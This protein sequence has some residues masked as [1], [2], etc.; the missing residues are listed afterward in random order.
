MKDC[1]I[2]EK[3][4]FDF[5]AQVCLVFSQCCFDLFLAFVDLVKL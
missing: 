2:L 3:P 5:S 1:S 4:P